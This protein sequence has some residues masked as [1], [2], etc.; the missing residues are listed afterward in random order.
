MIAAGRIKVDEMMS[1][2]VPLSEAAA[3]FHRL[4]QGEPGLMKVIVQP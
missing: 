3:W 2:V 1:A 4:Y